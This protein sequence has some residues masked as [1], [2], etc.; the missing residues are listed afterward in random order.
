MRRKNQFDEVMIVNP[1][2]GSANSNERVRL[3]RFHNV[4]P[5]QVGGFAEQDQYGYYA[6]PEA[7]GYYAEP[8][9]FSYYGE[10]DPAMGYYS[11]VDPAFGYYAEANPSLGY[12]SEVEPA[13]GY[14][15]E[16]DLSMGYYSEVDPTFGYYSE[17]DPP[18]GYYSEAEPRC[19]HY[20][21]AQEIPGVGVYNSYG[22]YQPAG[23]EPVGYFAENPIGYYGEDP[24]QSMGHYGQ[25]PEMIGYGETQQQFAEDYPG[26]SFYGEQ[27]FA[28]PEFAG[29]SGYTRDMP[30]SFNAGCPLPTNLSGYGD[31][32]RFDGYNAPATVNPTCDTMTPQPGTA[33][34]TPD[35]FKPLW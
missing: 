23:T 8:Q 7:Y 22:E 3:M 2:Q 18:F 24:N 11:E 21:E 19:G 1:S 25:T 15:G 16:P 17:V 34:S 10:A 4:F 20:A 32:D 28:E 14:Y 35:T 26:V 29:Y 13:Y 27:D 5:P 12:Y 30:P 33:P 6:E 31:V 9:P